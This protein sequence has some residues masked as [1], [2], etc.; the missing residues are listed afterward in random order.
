MAAR[1]DH[2][3][4]PESDGRAAEANDKTHWRLGDMDY[5]TLSATAS[6]TDVSLYWV[7]RQAIQRVVRECGTQP[8]LRLML[9]EQVSRKESSS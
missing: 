7:I 8:K 2:R 5:A 1:R 6:K 9:A 4:P 3:L